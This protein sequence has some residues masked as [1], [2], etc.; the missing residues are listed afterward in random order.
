MPG[1]R[2]IDVADLDLAALAAPARAR[3]RCAGRARRRLDKGPRKEEPP[4]VFPRSSALSATLFLGLLAACS[5]PS[6]SADAGDASAPDSGGEAGPP[7]RSAA[8]EAQDRKLQA[9]LDGARKSPNALLAV[10]NVEC[11][12]SV[13]VSGDP[14]TATADSLWR[15]GSVTKTY[16]SAAVL[17]AAQEGKL[18]LD[19]L[20][21]K[22]VPN[23]AGTTGVTIRMLLGHRS[24]IFNY[25]EDPAFLGARNQPWTPQQLV[26][27]A[28]AHAPYFAAGTDFHYSN[29][30]Y[31]L[32]GM[33]LEKATM[34]KAGAALHARALAPAKLSA[35]FLDGEDA[36]DRSRLARGFWNGKDVTLSIDPSGPWTAGA[37]VA[38]GADVADWVT[39]LYGSDAVLGSAQRQELTASP[40]AFGAGAKYGL[41]VLML[42]PSV[43]AG[44]GPGLGH[45][46]AID[47]FSTQAFF[48]PEKG[49][50][51]VAIVNAQ[52]ASANDVTLAAMT[53]LF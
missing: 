8:C 22:W 20:L 10:R 25:T 40:S 30:N 24:G 1:P 21:S 42:A 46:G 5:S 3:T 47:G 34:A 18:G 33:I 36:V 43:T 12:T 6:S 28:T 51:I 7:V 32:L 49:T 45:D 23:V 38:T 9:A 4:P 44:A 16:V 48:F 35:T 14:K 2:R 52:E 29:T 13:Y 15:I 11:G 41:G 31:V 50:A 19:D 27:L 17:S 53:A 39:A 26:D 37:M